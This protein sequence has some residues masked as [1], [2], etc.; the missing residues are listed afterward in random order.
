MTDNSDHS[1]KRRPAVLVG[2]QRRRLTRRANMPRSNTLSVLDSESAA[3]SSVGNVTN[4]SAT[5]L[6]ESASASGTPGAV[7]VATPLQSSQ[8]MMNFCKFLGKS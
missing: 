7:A 6:Q 1:S 8:S 4:N 2:G 3:T 5:N